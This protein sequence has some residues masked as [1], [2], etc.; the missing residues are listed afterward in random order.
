MWR[1]LFPPRFSEILRFIFIHVAFD[2]EGTERM[3]R[4]LIAA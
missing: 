2:C 4:G 1:T 3:D